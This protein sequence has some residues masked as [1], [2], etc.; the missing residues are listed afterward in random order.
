MS[1]KPFFWSERLELL[2]RSRVVLF[3]SLLSSASYSQSLLLYH[4]PTVH[5][6]STPILPTYYHPTSPPTTNYH[7]TVRLLPYTSYLLSA[8]S[9]GNMFLQFILVPPN[10]YEENSTPNNISTD[11]STCPSKKSGLSTTSTGVIMNEA[12]SHKN[13]KLY[14]YYLTCW[15]T[16]YESCYTH[17]EITRLCSVSHE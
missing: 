11:V 9:T 8:P 5:L 10:L 6:L 2:H 7:P 15:Y 16:A 14:N 3:R 1:W 4:L 12:S 17:Q 13:L